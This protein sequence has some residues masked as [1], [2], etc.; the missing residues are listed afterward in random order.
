[1]A[2]NAIPAA[3]LKINTKQG[4]DERCASVTLQQRFE[5]LLRE[6]F[7]RHDEYLGMTPD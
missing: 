3:E 5:K 4:A 1:M 2:A 6:V 7:E